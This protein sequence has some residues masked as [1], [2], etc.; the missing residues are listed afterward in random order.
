MH[1]LDPPSCTDQDFMFLL[2]AF[3]HSALVQWFNIRHTI[4][5]K[6]D[7]EHISKQIQIKVAVNS[8]LTCKVAIQILAP[9]LIAACC[10]LLMLTRGVSEYGSDDQGIFQTDL[11]YCCAGFLGWWLCLSWSIYS[12]LTQSMFRIGLLV[13]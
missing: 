4:G 12:I 9:S 2:Q 7:E 3:F 6:K 13:T 11:V 8:F 5:H 10:A 1:L